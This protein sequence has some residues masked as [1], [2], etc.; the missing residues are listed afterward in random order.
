MRGPRDKSKAGQ[1]ANEEVT[2]PNPDKV[3]MTVWKCPDCSY[4]NEL[5][6]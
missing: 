6:S 4:L 5:D 2:K 1:A 3:M